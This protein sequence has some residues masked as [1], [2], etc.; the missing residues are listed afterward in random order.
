MSSNSTSSHSLAASFPN[1]STPLLPTSAPNTKSSSVNLVKLT[2][3]EQKKRVYKRFFLF[4]LWGSFFTFCFNLVFLPRTSLGRDLK[5]LH[6]DP[7]TKSDLKRIY[8]NT[9]SS[10]NSDHNNHD[11]DGDSQ[12]TIAQKF[13]DYIHNYNLNNIDSKFR[14]PDHI[15]NY[16]NSSSEPIVDYTLNSFKKSGLKQSYIESYDINLNIPIKTDLLLKDANLNTLYHPSLVEPSISE[17]PLTKNASIFSKSFNPF[18]KSAN[19]TSTFSFVN[20]ASIDD[21]K[22]ISHSNI[23]IN[24]TICII[25]NGKLSSYL[26]IKNS[27]KNGCI[28]A[29]FFNDPSDDGLFTIKN[30]YN[31]YPNGFSRNPNSIERNT[32]N[33]I[34][35]FSQNQYQN[36]NENQKLRKH[37]Y[38]TIPSIPISYK[39]ILPVLAKI[40]GK[41][42]NFN[43]WSG[44]L[45]EDFDYSVG[46][47]D[48][49]HLLNLIN[50]QSDQSKTIKNIIAKIPGI[51]PGEDLIIGNHRDSLTTNGNLGGSA[52]L[53][54]ISRGLGNLVKL[55][56][57]PLRTITL[58]SWDAKEYGML[59]SNKFGEIH[60]SSLMKNSLGY[61]NIDNNIVYGTNFNVNSNP[62]YYNLIK[63]VSKLIPF[64]T[65]DDSDISLFQYWKSQDNN[66]FGISA[67]D[68]DYSVFQNHLTIPTIDIK[69]TSN[70]DKDPVFHKNSIYNSVNW[71]QNLTDNEFNYHQTLCKFIG[72]LILTIDENEL[73]PFKTNDY[74][75]HVF[76]SFKK[77]E[78]SI[79][80]DWYSKILSV[81]FLKKTIKDEPELKV[82]IY[83]F[84]RYYKENKIIDQKNRNND[85]H[86][87]NT[88]RFKDLTKFMFQVLSNFVD[89]SQIFDEYTTSIQDQVTNDYPWFKAYK[90]IKL[91]IQI[92]VA[93]F[94]LVHLD[95]KF[96]YEKGINDRKW[97]RHL[98]FAPDRETG[99]I[100]GILPGLDE[101]IKD[102]NFEKSCIWILLVLSRIHQ[103]IE[104]LG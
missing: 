32:L 15:H 90:K 14:N 47:S 103:L 65:D 79:N 62:L 68:S 8:L 58:I 44:D 48:S 16:L 78:K 52:V 33:S 80:N 92:K 11:N 70:K 95:R 82:I 55:G 25:R 50:L 98:I 22:S 13:L 104:N 28:G 49:N 18:S 35:L 9:I 89:Q 6:F 12:N 2:G 7:L 5:R 10:T 66:S 3:T 102:N 57:K 91:A 54:E 61:I 37:F 17:D 40:N 20:Y 21:F 86:D 36:E 69:F 56:W 94:K 71:L 38:P 100:G 88:I 67:S 42:P 84:L 76:E 53:L 85:D 29:I 39:E 43:N 77:I 75:L 83:H 41:N 34:E 101:S 31:T 26:K 59:G 19:I 64:N 99:L 1:D 72:L 81:Q 97:L 87:L 27:E 51:L 4:C 74:S 45:I 96:Y 93:N 46:P 23:N 73:I 60:S 63:K 24:N 30:G